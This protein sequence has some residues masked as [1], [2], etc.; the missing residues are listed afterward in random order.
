MIRTLGIFLLLSTFCMVQG[1][2]NMQLIGS[3]PFAERINDIW[4]YENNQG[5]QYALIGSESAINIVDVTIPSNPI[6][7]FSI[8]GATSTWRDVK[9]Y[10]DFAY[11][12]N[13]ENGGLLIVDLRDLPNFV[14]FQNITQ[15]DSFDIRTAHNIFI[16]E[17]GV[18]YILGSNISNQGAFM[19]DLNTTNR[20]APTFLGLYDDQYVHDAYAR[21][22][23]LY[24]AEINNGTFSIIDVSNKQDPIVLAREETSRSFTHNIWLSDDGNYVATTD[25]KPGAFVDLYDIS[26]LNNIKLLDKYQSSPNDSLIPHNTFFK[27]DY[28]ISSYYRDG[29]TIVDATVKDNL[30]EV[31]NYDTSP[32]P[33]AAG[34]EGNW[35]VYPYLSSGNLLVSDREEGLFI[36]NANYVRAA[37][38]SGNVFDT[39]NNFPVSDAIIE[40]IGTD[41]EKYSAFNGDYAIG[42][43]DSGYYD[44]RMNH[45]KCRTIIASNVLLETGVEKILNFETSC[46]FA[47]GISHLDED[48]RIK[49]FNN[50]TSQSIRFEIVSSSLLKTVIIYDLMGKELRRIAVD[51]YDTTLIIADNLPRGIYISNFV[52][53]DKELSKKFVKY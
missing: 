39:L 36:L 17:N 15:I 51:S 32:F 47:T 23:T 53:E 29:L 24:T 44:I 30:V 4:G 10:E 12:V 41:Y 28:L 14:L 52:F 21:G 46:D 22:D 33:S 9:V 16:D 50:T 42:V 27:N 49:V 48:N 20:Y 25:E 6:L 38:L 34:Y 19:I 3:L 2:K 37:Y 26:N 11:V 35:G 43:V 13:E 45:P 18:G 40:V 31:G 8:Q 7:L 1:Q 5:E